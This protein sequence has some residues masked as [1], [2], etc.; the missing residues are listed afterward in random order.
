MRT[1]VRATDSFPSDQEAWMNATATRRLFP[2]AVIACLLYS[3]SGFA[4]PC[5]LADDGLTLR[6]DNDFFRLTLRPPKGGTSL[7][8]FYKATGKQLIPPVESLPLFADT[9]TECG[10]RGPWVGSTYEYEILSNT[11]EKISVHLWGKDGSTFPFVYMHKT[12]T[13]YRDR[14]YIEVDHAVE[15]DAN[16]MVPVYISPWWHNGLAVVGEHTQYVTP[17]P[18]GLARCWDVESLNKWCNHPDLTRPW[19]AMIGKSG[20]GL[21]IELTDYEHLETVWQS[22]Y[23][24]E[25]CFEWRFNRVKI[26]QGDRLKTKFWL[27]PFHGLTGVDGVGGRTVGYL[28]CQEKLE[29]AKPVGAK[30]EVCSGE[31]VSAKVLVTSARLPDGQPKTLLEERTDLVASTAQAFDFTFDPGATG[32]FVLHCVVSSG[33]RTICE[34]EKPIV[35][36]RPSGE[37]RM[38]P[39]G[40]RIPPEIMERE[41]LT[42]NTEVVTPHVK[43]AKPYYKGPVKALVLTEIL[44][45]RG[46]VELAQRMDLDFT[47]V[48]MSN[49]DSILRYYGAPEEYGPPT[50][51]ECN[52]C[53]TTALKSDYDVIL[54]SGLRWDRFSAPNR[55]AI[56][57]KASKGTGLIY[58]DP[59]TVPR[60]LRAALGVYGAARRAQYEAPVEKLSHFLSNS[61]PYR[62]LFPCPH[63]AF[64]ADLADGRFVPIE[65]TGGHPLV[66]ARDGSSRTL[67]LLYRSASSQAANLIPCWHGQYE[68]TWPE[69]D[70]GVR[71]HYWEPYYA[72]L[73]RC[74]VWAARKEPDITIKSF[75]T[76]LEPLAYGEPPEHAVSVVVA[77]SSDSRTQYRAELVLRDEEYEPQ[78]TMKQNITLAKGE[79]QL[80]FR[81]P[82][83]LRHGLQLADLRLMMSDGKVVTWASR[84]FNV[85][86][87]VRIVS[88]HLDKKIYSSEDR[89]DAEI[90]LEGE[91]KEI[92]RCDATVT[93]SH[94]RLLWKQSQRRNLGRATFGAQ[95]RL[96]YGIAIEPIANWHQFELQLRCR[97][98]L[99]QRVTKDFL[100]FPPQQQ[101]REWDDYV[102]GRTYPLRIPQYWLM[103]RFNAQFASLGY[104]KV[105]IWEHAFGRKAHDAEAAFDFFRSNAT[106]IGI[107]VSTRIMGGGAEYRKAI[108]DYK[109]AYKQTGDKMALVRE[110]C[111]D[112]PAFWEE[113]GRRIGAT[114]RSLRPFRVE[115]Y[116]LG[117]EDTLTRAGNHGDCCYSPHTLREFRVWLKNEYGSL[118][119]LNAEWDTDFQTWDAVVPMTR[120]EVR[121]RGNYAPWA[122]HRTYMED[123][124]ARS[125]RTYREYVHQLAP[126]SFVGN[127]GSQVYQADNGMDYWKFFREWEQAQAR[128]SQYW[129]PK[130]YRSFPDAP[131]VTPYSAIGWDRG[132]DVARYWVWKTAFEM[133][134]AGDSAYPSIKKVAPDLSI[135]R[136]GRTV[137]EITRPLRHGVGKLLRHLD[138]VWDGVAIHYSQPSIHGELIIGHAE[139]INQSQLVWVYLLR[140]LGIDPRYV[141]YEQ[142]EQGELTKGGYKLFILPFSVALSKEEVG[143]IKAFAEQGGVVI[144]DAMTGIMDDHCKP[145]DP[146]PVDDLFGLRRGEHRGSRSGKVL[147]APRGPLSSTNRGTM[148]LTTFIEGGLKPT[149]AKAIGRFSAG[150]SGLLIN[151]YGKGKA[152]RLGF[153]LSGYHDI[154]RYD[155][156]RREHTLRL[157]NALLKMADVSRQVQVTTKDG[158][159]LRFSETWRF[160]RGTTD[161]VGVVR[162]HDPKANLQ[163]EAVVITLP[164]TRHVY[165][166]VGGKYLGKTNRIETQMRPAHSAFYALFHEKVRDVRVQTSPNE[167]GRSPK[168]PALVLSYEIT[169]ASE[170]GEPQDHALRVEVIGPDGKARDCYAANVFAPGGRAKG[171]VRFAL[172]D[173]PGEWKI[174]VRD[175]ASSLAAEETSVV[176]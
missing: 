121:N 49:S 51:L 93:D 127:G 82:S 175:V 135:S 52:D 14:C 12:I 60:D 91:T 132:D 117:D 151:D 139:N 166:I 54:I 160:R 153:L 131:I 165:D 83:H 22:F 118:N 25:W 157:V 108:D 58:I 75:D 61:L 156:R 59:P 173:A 140:D 55:K 88:C 78:A 40:E 150:D 124:W 44:G 172:N 50:I 47:T 16:N 152:I 35:V 56:L 13:I 106:R 164:E 109:K 90:V 174:A 104:D 103:D 158:A 79:A 168:K 84:S 46:I 95:T 161:Y 4:G 98:G 3:A 37:Y 76:P 8:F 167:L 31:S 85:R 38:E 116:Y 65:T 19:S 99:I 170:A 30:L 129:Y 113:E 6:L 115:T 80:S 48:K 96:T 34:F 110:P 1:Y 81:L 27:I 141:S 105:D 43:W 128:Y 169:V 87:P 112:D 15:V 145:W 41:P 5:R 148:L 155:G 122:D 39:A 111:L 119:A 130:L 107:V 133:R 64:K 162:E 26:N 36:G 77:K 69:Y 163:D 9:A 101:R 2:T 142:V 86:A 149:S 147:V 32:T 21:G 137:E 126:F 143:Q 97:A 20:T 136:S 73:A 23:Q 10:W 28:N 70:Y 18:P 120:G 100:T 53:L 45:V 123:A 29:S 138:I 11:P 94:G 92:L 144:G 102:L 67:A 72:F 171:T 33:E 154:I 68:K 17:V 66:V 125:Y 57:D 62:A 89:I 71:Y 146:S 74:L 24:R 63:R 42:L 176:K 134:G 7:D 114:V 159:P